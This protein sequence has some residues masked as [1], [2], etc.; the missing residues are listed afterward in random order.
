MIESKF[1]EATNTD[2]K[3][4]GINWASL[5][6]MELSSGVISRNWN[7]T[8]GGG[9]NYSEGY[10]TVY[11][12]DSGM[13]VTIPAEE[14]VS[15]SQYLQNRIDSAVMT[16]S[17][18]KVVLSA[19]KSNTDVKL[20]SNPTVVTLN[21]TEA[22]INIGE[23][24][25]IPKFTYNEERGTFEISD[26]NYKSIGI[27][28]SVTPQVNSAG[29]INL[30]IS[31]EVSAR[32][33]EV[34]LGGSTGTEVPI[35]SSRK[36]S[37][38]ITIKNGYT[39]A[40]GGLIETAENNNVSKVPLL[41]DIPGLGRLFRSDS[42]ELQQRNLIIFITAKTL[43]PDGADYREVIDS[44]ML[45]EMG[46]TDK[47][48]PGYELTDKENELYQTIEEYRQRVRD[49]EDQMELESQLGGLQ[50]LETETQAE[51]DQAEI[52]GE[53]GDDRPFILKRR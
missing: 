49:L 53:K 8:S 30:L 11:D 38:N 40:I 19:L 48:V 25:P 10:T 14:S 43:N 5:N 51:K 32:A 41:G 22:T 50:T 13:G 52:T 4:I 16:A 39:L 17:E 23:D 28:L 36:T 47:D 31:P 1:V 3:N 34:Q 18:F 6:G 24:Y 21:N 7:R 44:R 26:I 35:I 42:K 33:G 45:H 29:F 9:N 27:N 20:V 15:A 37:T 12:E 2:A 46:I